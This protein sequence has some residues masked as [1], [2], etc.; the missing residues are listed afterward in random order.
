MEHTHS[1]F[2]IIGIKNDEIHIKYVGINTQ[3]ELFIV[4]FFLLS[5]YLTVNI[6]YN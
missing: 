6:C 4:L 1:G 5:I 2:L 3:T